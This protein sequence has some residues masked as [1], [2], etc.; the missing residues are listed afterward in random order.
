MR[1]M[2]LNVILRPGRLP[3]MQLEK[4]EEHRKL[5]RELGLLIKFLESDTGK[6]RDVQ[7]PRVFYRREIE[8]SQWVVAKP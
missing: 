1:L 8:T 3:E 7:R 5:G 6:D 2:H 4:M